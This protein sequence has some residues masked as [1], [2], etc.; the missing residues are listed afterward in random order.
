MKIDENQGK[1]TKIDE[2]QRNREE[3]VVRN[4]ARYATDRELV[5]A[6]GDD[7]ESRRACRTCITKCKLAPAAS[8]IVPA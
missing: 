2:N 5:P 7:P 3:T 1:A 4:P 8:V 6:C